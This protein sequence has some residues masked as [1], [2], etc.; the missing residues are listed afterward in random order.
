MIPFG[1]EKVQ[2]KVLSL[3]KK[4]KKKDSRFSVSAYGEMAR[5]ECLSPE[6]HGAALSPPGRTQESATVPGQLLRPFP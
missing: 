5:K 2:G 4:K 6:A 3:F 1:E